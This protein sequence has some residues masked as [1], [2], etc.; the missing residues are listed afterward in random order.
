VAAAGQAIDVAAV[1]DRLC[2][3]YPVGLVDAVSAL[4]P[5]ARISAVKNVTIN[6]GFFQGHFPEVPLMPGV[7]LIESLTQAA[8]LLLLY[9]GEQVCNARTVL[10]RVT[11]TKFR[12]QVTPGDQVTLDIAIRRRRG[13]MARL[14][15]VAS[16]GGQV[17]AEAELLRQ[18]RIG[19]CA[20][21]VP[22]LDA[23][24]LRPGAQHQHGDLQRADAGVD[25]G[26][27]EGRRV[28]AAFEGRRAGQLEALAVGRRLQAVLAVV[29]QRLGVEH[30]VRR[31]VGEALE[32][33]LR[34]DKAVL[35]LRRRV[36]RARWRQ[37][38][39]VFGRPAD[40][41]VHQH[42]LAQTPRREGRGLHQRMRAHAVAN[43]HGIFCVQRFQQRRLVAAEVGPAVEAGAAAAAVA[44]LVDRDHMVAGQLVDHL[45]PH[46]AVE[47]SGMHHPQRR[48]VAAQVCPPFMASQRQAADV[49]VMQLRLVRHPQTSAARRLAWLMA[50]LASSSAAS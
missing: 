14:S 6:E 49:E 27:A 9:D 31:P 21:R 42:Q 18:L 50:R 12:R 8:T 4:E 40:H 43:A 24:V 20:Q 44:A 5:G 22:G 28:D 7:L 37:R 39:V 23:R 35:A 10:R 47:A 15:A 38:Q 34:R 11:G 30:R 16:V 29:V 17:A 45:V 25:A 48:R 32:H 13:P 19:R 36:Q 33:L 3:R 41:R 46:P 1:L 26:V 2:H